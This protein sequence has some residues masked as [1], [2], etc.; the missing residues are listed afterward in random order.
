MLATILSPFILTA[1]PAGLCYL[2][3]GGLLI[4]Q[5]MRSAPKGSPQ[6][7]LDPRIFVAMTV[8]LTGA[9]FFSVFALII[10]LY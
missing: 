3:F 2:L 9:V 7:K 10:C 8:T 5:Q 1:V 6:A 4:R